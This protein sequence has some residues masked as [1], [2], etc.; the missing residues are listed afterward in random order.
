MAS[1]DS[2]VMKD[3]P[4]KP[5]AKVPASTSKAPGIGAGTAKAVSTSKKMPDLKAPGVGSKAT[6]KTT[7]KPGGAG[8]DIVD[9]IT[10][11]YRVTA[12]EAGA[13][14]KKVADYAKNSS[15]Q[16]GQ[17]AKATVKQ[18]ANNYSPKTL[19]A[20]KGSSADDKNKAVAT[21]TRKQLGQAV[22]AV[23]QNRKYKD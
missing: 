1:K 6:T 14:V 16:V 22:G 4:K 11:N 3:M 12:K 18:V 21:N 10:Q 23:T 19:G 20:L 13:I 9:H 17:A 5:A 2:R 15:T 8:K 7:P